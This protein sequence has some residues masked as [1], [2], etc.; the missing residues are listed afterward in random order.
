MSR[1]EFLEKFGGVEVKFSSY[2]KYSFVFSGVTE[3]GTYVSVSIGGNAD[4][5]YRLDVSADSVE[6]V[7]GLDPYQGTAIL[8]KEI[9]AEFYDY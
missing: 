7:V 5:I 3:D 6:T 8:N 2:Y 4:D 9:V 1:A